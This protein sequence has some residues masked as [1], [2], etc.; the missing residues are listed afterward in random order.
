MLTM[1][2]YAVHLVFHLVFHNGLHLGLFHFQIR[3]RKLKEIK[4]GWH[5]SLFSSFNVKSKRLD[6][7]E[8]APVWFCHLQPWL[9]GPSYLPA[10]TK[11]S[12]NIWT[13]GKGPLPQKVPLTSSISSVHTMAPPKCSFFTNIAY[14]NSSQL[15][16]TLQSGYMGER[17]KMSKPTE[18][19]EGGHLW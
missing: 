8:W 19:N 11:T 16:T 17:Q 3:Q 1:K 5:W 9:L 6:P 13:R 4:F 12:F 2:E 18:G 14:K 15:L 10:C 7:E